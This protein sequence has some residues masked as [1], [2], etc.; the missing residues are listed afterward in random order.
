VN[1]YVDEAVMTEGLPD[2][3]KVD[4]LLFSM[5]NFQYFGLGELLGHVWSIAPTF[6]PSPD[7]V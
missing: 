7:G 6:Q 2:M 1:A 5:H 4:P 3:A